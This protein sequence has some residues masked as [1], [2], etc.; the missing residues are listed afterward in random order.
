M[1]DTDRRLVAVAGKDIRLTKTE[2]ELLLYFLKN[3][4]RILTFEQIYNAV[5]NEEYYTGNSTIFYHVGNLRKK[6]GIDWIES[7][8]GIGYRI[9]TIK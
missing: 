5:W 9:C 3:G 7:E 8:Y 1:L 2:Y 6:M 4:N